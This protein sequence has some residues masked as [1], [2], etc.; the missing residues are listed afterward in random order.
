M[1]KIFQVKSKN[2]SENAKIEQTLYLEVPARISFEI[3]QVFL[4]KP[5]I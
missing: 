1:L 4:Q 2:A 3:P 5:A